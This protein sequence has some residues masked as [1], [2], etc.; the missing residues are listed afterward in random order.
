M[1]S[2]NSIGFWKSESGWYLSSSIK[3]ADLDSFLKNKNSTFRIIMRYNK[4]HKKNDDRPPF[5]GFLVNGGEAKYHMEFES[6]EYAYYDEENDVWE[7]KY[8]ERLYT[9]EEVQYA[10]NRAAEDGARGYGYGDNIV[11]DYL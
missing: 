8:G 6:K 1:K 5:Y 7:T 2:K 3:R 4:Q 9:R 11:E 10:I